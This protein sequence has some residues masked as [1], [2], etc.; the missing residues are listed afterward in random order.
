MFGQS[1]SKKKKEDNEGLAVKS[2]RGNMDEY[3]ALRTIVA[4]NSGLLSRVLEKIRIQRAMSGTKS[5]ETPMP[6]DEK[7]RQERR[8]VAA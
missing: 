7:K 8:E 5:G 6:A 3:E 2:A 4:E 1:G